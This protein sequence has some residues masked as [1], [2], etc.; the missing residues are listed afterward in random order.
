MRVKELSLSMFARNPSRIIRHLHDEG[1]GGGDLA[2][3]PQ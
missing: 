2:C 1:W 3:P